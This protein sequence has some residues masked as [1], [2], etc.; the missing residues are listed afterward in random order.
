MST[1]L[2]TK[3][4]LLIQATKVQPLAPINSDDNERNEAWFQ[5][6]LF[7]NPSLLRANEIDGTVK[8]LVPIAR[9][10]ETDNGIIDLLF[11]DS[12]GFIVVVETKLYRNPE[13]RRKVVGQIIEY[14]ANLS[15]WSYED[16]CGAVRKATESSAADPII[17]IFR[18]LKIDIDESGFAHSVTTNLQRGR[19]LLIVA[20][21]EIQDSIVKMEQF[22]NQH[23][24]LTFHFAA[25]ELAVYELPDG[26]SFI[27]Q[28]KVV[29]QTKNVTR[30]I[31]EVR[32]TSK[33]DD[34]SIKPGDISIKG[35]ELIAAPAAKRAKTSRKAISPEEFFASIKDISDET[36]KLT[37][38]V[39]EEAPKHGLE[40]EWRPNGPI[41]KY[42]REVEGKLKDFN[43]GQLDPYGRLAYSGWLSAKCGRLELPNSIWENYYK[44][45]AS[46]I[47]DATIFK[48]VIDDEDNIDEWAI[49]TVDG[50]DVSA[51]SLLKNKAK[52]FQ[53]IDETITRINAECSA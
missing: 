9:E 53:A 21:D 49:V 12:N 29:A 20:G 16:F 19:M 32:G 36:L 39:L 27:V 22:F 31:V 35:P 42:F 51:E 11:I 3:N 46:L 8:Q 43:F 24:Q 33:V 15:T 7:E 52:W 2:Q 6:L 13:S 47:P 28:P 37:K 40:V 1:K 38:E 14:A 10:L 41:L 34:I 45:V 4:L 18:K 23:A 25:V 48:H 44:T 26:K 17:E 30:Y 50:E 5:K